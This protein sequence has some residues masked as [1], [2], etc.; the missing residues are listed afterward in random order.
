MSSH[1]SS[2]EGNSILDRWDQ[3]KVYR[4]RKR[5]GEGLVLICGNRTRKTDIQRERVGREGRK[6]ERKLF[7]LT[8]YLTL[9]TL[10]S[11]ENIFISLPKSENKWKQKHTIVY[12][13]GNITTG[14]KNCLRNSALNW[15]FFP[16]RTAKG[17][18]PPQPASLQQEASPVTVKLV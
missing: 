14:K 13:T 18:D 7:L 16:G 10:E 15:N 17:P 2:E 5:A 11:F 3:S 8:P 4:C 9:Y 12:Q 6:K 1:W